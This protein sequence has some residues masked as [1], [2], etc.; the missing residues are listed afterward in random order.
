MGMGEA[1][2]EEFGE[3]NSLNMELAWRVNRCVSCRIR[4]E[5][6]R[7]H[8]WPTTCPSLGTKREEANE[9]AWRGRGVCERDV[10]PR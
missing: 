2:S 10:D 6:R 5:P 3:R 1:S 9:E 7:R 4:S 8:T